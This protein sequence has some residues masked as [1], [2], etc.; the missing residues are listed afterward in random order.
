MRDVDI[1]NL[2]VIVDHEHQDPAY[3]IHTLEH[4]VVPPLFEYQAN[5]V[6]ETATE[7]IGLRQNPHLPVLGHR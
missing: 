6:D 4:G 2:E 7:R 3:W 5:L 1:L